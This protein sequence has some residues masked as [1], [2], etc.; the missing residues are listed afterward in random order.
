MEKGSF[1]E[2]ILRW[3][4]LEVEV[5]LRCQKP[6]FSGG[7]GCH[8]LADIWASQRLGETDWEVDAAVVD[9]WVHVNMK[10]LGAWSWLRMRSVDEV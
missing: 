6:F 10:C 5:G 1:S 2:S 9:D 7:E 3:E 8:R 4:E